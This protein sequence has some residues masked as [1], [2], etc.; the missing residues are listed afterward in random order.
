MWVTSVAADSLRSLEAVEL[1]PDRKVTAIV[2]PNGA[3]KTNLVEAVYFGLTGRSF[4]TA[5]RRDLVPFGR[6]VARCRV[7]VRSGAG[8]AAVDHE[9]MASTSRAEGS[10][11]TMDGAA[12]ERS[13]AA[14]HRPA[15]TVFSPDRLELVK[16][17]PSGRRAHIDSYIAA[18]WPA[19]GE[20]RQR[21][22]R[23]LSQRNALIARLRE[24]AGD[25]NQLTTWNQ[26][27]ATTGSELAGAREAAVEELQG[28]FTAAVGDL[29]LE[30][31][32]GLVYRPGAAIEAAAI[33]AG[34]EE[35]FETD[36]RLGRTSWGPHHDEIRLELDGRQ[37]RRFG[38][39]GQQR[40]GLLAL[41]FA[42]RSA[43]LGGGASPPLM[44]LDDVMSELDSTRRKRLVE[45]LL[46]GG[47]SLIT[48]AEP[49]LIPPGA[50][51]HRV[52]IEEL[53]GGAG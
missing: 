39:Q 35:R 8:A 7:L 38:S 47:Q 50:G 32:T 40:I 28:H 11:Y 6:T 17:P 36:L 4:R 14:I 25:R 34:L 51:V 46:D 22:G 44:L 19:R 16:G 9:F 18:R 12:I 41:L 48:A 27:V 30:G 5:D 20:L 3:G 1:E 37:L 53:I 13:E 42:E 31:G 23:A 10:R 15:A 29:G 24:G 43:I 21:F 52:A 49:D 33:E 2:G 26:Q 45:R